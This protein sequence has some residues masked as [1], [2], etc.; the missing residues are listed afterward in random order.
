MTEYDETLPPWEPVRDALL[1]VAERLEQGTPDGPAVLNDVLEV[2]SAVTRDAD[3]A[4]LAGMLAHFLIPE[5]GESNRQYAARLR[6]EV[7]G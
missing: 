2:A 4:V 5:A 1:A 7:G 6:E 3:Q